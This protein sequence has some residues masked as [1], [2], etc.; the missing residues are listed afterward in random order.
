[1]NSSAAW[2]MPKDVS[3]RTLSPRVPWKKRARN[4]WTGDCT[5][6][7]WIPRRPSGQPGA[8]EKRTPDWRIGIPH[9]QPAIHTLIKAG[10]PILKSLDLLANR[11]TSPKLRPVISQIRDRVREGKSLSEAVAEAGVFSK[12]IPRPSWREKRAA[13][14]PVCWTT[15]SLSARQHRR[16]QKDSRNPGLSRSVAQRCHRYRDLPGHCRDSKFALL[17]RDLNVELPTPT[18]LLIALTVDYRL[19]FWESWP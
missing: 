6:I 15:T 13:I 8:S 17:Y 12:V 10:L 18:R 7:R 19:L 11:A 14:C 4:W 2:R 5:S 1:V 9:S 3:F 16:S